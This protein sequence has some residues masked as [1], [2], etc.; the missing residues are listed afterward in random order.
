MNRARGVLGELVLKGLSGA[1]A[2]GQRMALLASIGETGS[3]SQ[4]AKALGLSYKGAWDG[5]Q[6]LNNLFEPPLIEARPGGRG[7]GSATLTL[8]G[9]HVLR[10]HAL[11][12]EKISDV[13]S[14]LGDRVGP[15]QLETARRI[16]MGTEMR[17][18]VENVLTGRIVSVEIGAVNVEVCLRVAS[19]IV[20]TAMVTRHG[21]EQLT[22]AS[23]DP[24]CALFPAQSVMLAVGEGP[25]VSARNQL[26]GRVSAV[27][28]G[29]VNDEIVVDIALGKTLRAIVT[30]ASTEHLGF[31]V[32]TKVTALIKASSIIL[33]T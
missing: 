15:E 11:L 16:I 33:S 14:A 13:V 28:E 10:L 29:A 2:G 6:A 9:E 19:D 8:E 18:S 4:S 25:S 7:G 3:I 5:V 24:A 30:R 12:S 1:S 31:A 26:R 17:T 32:G 23:G 21:W 20:L 22:L 27:H